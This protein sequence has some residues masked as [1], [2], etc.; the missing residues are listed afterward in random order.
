MIVGVLGAVGCQLQ[1][2]LFE[3][4]LFIDDP[5]N[6]SAVHFGAGAVGMMF[7]AFF[8]NPE[9]TG[10]DNFTG[11]FYGGNFEFFGFQLYGM[12]VYAAWAGI[13]SSIMFFGMSKIGWLRVDEEEEYEGMDKSHHGGKAYPADDEHLVSDR[14]A[15]SVETSEGKASSKVDVDSEEIEG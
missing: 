11:I 15:S 6:A 13:L 9:Y 14:G 7:V 3:N 2:T 10:G 1:I 8:A 5:L 4:Y 12:V